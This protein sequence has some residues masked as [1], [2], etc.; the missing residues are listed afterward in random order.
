MEEN[1]TLV[2]EVTENVEQPTEETQQPP[3]K[4]YSQEEVDAIVGKAK[5]RAKAQIEKKYERK[6][7]NLETVLKAG[8]GKESVEEM[9]D[10]FTEF[11]KGK[12]I[13]IRKNPNYSAKDIEVLANASAQEV[14]NDGYDFVVDEVDRLAEIGVANMN[15][16]ERAYFNALC[17]HRTKIEQ[18][19]DLAKIGASEDVVNSQEFKDFA[20][21][22]NS[23]TPITEIYGY[24][25]KQQPK[26]DIKPMGS[27][28]NKTSDEG[29]VKDFYT[30]DE[31]LRYTKEDFDK[32]PALFE[33]VQKSM[34]KW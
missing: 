2:T 12:G 5:A 30:R 32:N 31:A 6:Y 3:A 17:K 11:Y 1:K 15:D 7:G 28:S 21:K 4:T 33:A 20:S 8:T 14:I 10:A 34:L 22:F 29:T 24:Y 26:K 9:T 16:R 19:N 27:L 23:N 13:E 18:Q 25:S